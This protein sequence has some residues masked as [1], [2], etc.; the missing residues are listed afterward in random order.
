MAGSDDTIQ[1]SENGFGTLR[2]QLAPA[3]FK[4]VENQS[5]Y[6]EIDVADESVIF[7]MFVTIQLLKK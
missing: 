1:E 3:T 6:A 5:F 2:E 7:M 4:M